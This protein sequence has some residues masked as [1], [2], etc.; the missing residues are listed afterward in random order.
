[1][2]IQKAVK[3]AMEVFEQKMEDFA[4]NADAM[5]LT[6]DLALD[7]SAAFEECFLRGRPFRTCSGFRK[8]PIFLWPAWTGLTFFCGNRVSSRSD[9]P[10]V[11]ATKTIQVKIQLIKMPWQE[12]YPVTRC[13]LNQRKASRTAIVLCCPNA[14]AGSDPVGGS[15]QKHCKNTFVPQWHAV[16]PP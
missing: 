8:R 13:R 6:A 9:R 12:R 7:F 1:M 16:E 3:L 15:L 5:E 2:I 11:P 4:G 14:S 10:N